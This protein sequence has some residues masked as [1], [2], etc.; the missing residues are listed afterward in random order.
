MAQT[1]KDLPAMQKTNLIPRSGRSSGEENDYPP[2]WRI[3]WTEEP[4][5]FHGQWSLAGYNPWG[6][7]SDYHFSLY[8]VKKLV[9]SSIGFTFYVNRI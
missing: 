2:A 1:I 9:L 4:G 5:E 8:L 6:H 7:L 3:P